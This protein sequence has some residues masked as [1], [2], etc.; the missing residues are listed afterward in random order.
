MS[1]FFV[2]HRRV[3]DWQTE[4]ADG[5]SPHEVWAALVT[6]SIRTS[7]LPDIAAWWLASG[8]DS[9]AL[10]ELGG[11]PPDDVWALDRLWERV[12]DDVG[13]ERPETPQ[14]RA[15]TCVESSVSGRRVANRCLACF[16]S[17]I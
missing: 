1:D 13:I 15:S 4:I 6:G 9:P 16:T 7:D 14:R 5:L 8:R 2:H 17:S 3:I 11:A 12:A 10:R